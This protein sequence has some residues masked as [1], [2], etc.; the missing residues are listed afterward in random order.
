MTDKPTVIRVAAEGNLRMQLFIEEFMVRLMKGPDR[1]LRVGILSVGKISSQIGFAPPTKYYWL[2]EWTII[3]LGMI[4]MRPF[5]PVPLTA[6][7]M[8]WAAL[9]SRFKIF[10]TSAE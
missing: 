3:G 5:P 1:G 4:S 7:A 8:A 2:P 10:K 6:S 9:I